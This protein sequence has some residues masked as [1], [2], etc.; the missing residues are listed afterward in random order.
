M[1]KTAVLAFNDTV[2]GPDTT[3]AGKPINDRDF[4]PVISLWDM[5]E[6]VEEVIKHI[7][8]KIRI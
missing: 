2:K 7:N 1:D 4:S 6:P 8:Q 5:I 3:K